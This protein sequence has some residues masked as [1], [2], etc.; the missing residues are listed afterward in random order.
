MSLTPARARIM[1]IIIEVALWWGV[2]SSFLLMVFPVLSEDVTRTGA[3]LSW[4]SVIAYRIAYHLSKHWIMSSLVVVAVTAYHTRT[5]LPMPLVRGL[6]VAGALLLSYLMSFV[7][8][9]M[10]LLPRSG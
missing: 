10:L 8:L 7:S 2:Y 5:P 1:D 9:P 4:T 6:R 3:E